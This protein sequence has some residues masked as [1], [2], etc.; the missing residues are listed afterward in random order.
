MMT[1]EISSKT[2]TRLAAFVG[3]GGFSSTDAALDFM[4][5]LATDRPSVFLGDR[6]WE[7]FV[8]E[9]PPE[10]DGLN[11]SIEAHRRLVGADG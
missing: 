10:P 6:A 3:R 2:E 5:S 7:T 9:G 8:S 4:L 11:S 1:I